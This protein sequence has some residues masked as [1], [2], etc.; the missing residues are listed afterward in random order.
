MA[1]QSNLANQFEFTQS[2]WVN[3]PGFIGPASGIDPV[4]GQTPGANGQKWPTGWN[5]PLKAEPYDFSD[6]VTMQGGEYFFAPS[7]SMLK[8][9]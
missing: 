9:V 7:L 1:Y 3:N 4:I 5:K 6:W 8:S 2:T